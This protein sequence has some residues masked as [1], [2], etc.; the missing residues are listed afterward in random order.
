VDWSGLS[1]AS[2]RVPELREEAA[3]VFGLRWRV[4]R[5][6]EANGWSAVY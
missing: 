5:K 2:R 1:T 6:I 4:A 3:V